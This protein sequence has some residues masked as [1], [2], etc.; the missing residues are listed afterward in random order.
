MPSQDFSIAAKGE[1][2]FFPI[3]SLTKHERESDKSW[4]QNH[5][6]FWPTDNLI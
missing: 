2:P 1:N 3:V 6:H 4:R 5:Q